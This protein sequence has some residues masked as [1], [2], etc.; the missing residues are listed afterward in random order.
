MTVIDVTRES[1]QLD[2]RTD[3]AL[4][5]LRLGFDILPVWGTRPK[6]DSFNNPLGHYYAHARIAGWLAARGALGSHIREV[7]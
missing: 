3:L 5:S 2:E 4:Q 1:G 6:A 7:P